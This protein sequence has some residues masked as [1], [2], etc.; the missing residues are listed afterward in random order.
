VSA[1]IGKLA[2]VYLSGCINSP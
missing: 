2:D 1:Q